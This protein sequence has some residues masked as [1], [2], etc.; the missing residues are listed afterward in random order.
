[1]AN[2]Q[3]QKV[4]EF[5]RS[6]TVKA[7]FAEV[8]GSNNAGAYIS[9]VLLAVANSDNLKECTV[10]SVY[11]SA[12]RAATLRLSCDP[13]TGQAY[14]VPF[15]GKATLIVGYKGLQDMAVRTGRYRFINTSPIYEGEEIKEDR[16]SGE[17]TLTGNKK[18][19]IL[20]G[21]LAAFELMGGYSKALYMSID[22]IHDHAKKYSKSYAFKESGWQ[23][24]PKEMERKTVL[25]RLL[26]QWGYLDPAD[27]SALETLESDQPGDVIDIPAADVTEPAEPEPAKDEAQLLKE[28]GFNQ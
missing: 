24:N 23:T 12:L 19:D 14:L 22:E 16:F 11:I 17:L 28:L 25:R 10:E 13:S 26:R 21:W 7:R 8:V 4:S 27:V 6:E 2:E 9:S 1:M 18:S 5:M 20:V 15:K 3:I